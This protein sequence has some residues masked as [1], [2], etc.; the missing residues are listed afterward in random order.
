MTSFSKELLGGF[1]F[2]LVPREGLHAIISLKP[3]LLLP[4]R[5]MIAYA[6]KQNNSAIFEWQEKE[7]GWFLYIGEFPRSWEKN[8]KVVKLPTLTKKGSASKSAKPKATKKGADTFEAYSDIVPYGAFLS[9]VTLSLR[10][11]LLLLPKLVPLGY[12]LQANVGPYTEAAF[13]CPSL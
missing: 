13:Q 9:L 6:R 5:F 1:R 4:T 7:Q 3:R 10:A 2:S 8:D 12:L 11:P